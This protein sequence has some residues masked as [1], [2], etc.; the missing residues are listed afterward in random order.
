M[1]TLNLVWYYVE[2][3]TGQWYSSCM[4]VIGH[5]SIVYDV[6]YERL[7]SEYDAIVDLQLSVDPLPNNIEQRIIQYFVDKKE[8]KLSC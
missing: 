3:D 8:P 1:E 5:T 6:V 4:I 2:I 7:M